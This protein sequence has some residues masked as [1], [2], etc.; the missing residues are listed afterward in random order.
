MR[1]RVTIVETETPCPHSTA[2]NANRWGDGV[3]LSDIEPLFICKASGKR[4]AE[5][6]SDFPQAR[7]GTDA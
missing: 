2:I 1:P 3:Q 6:R 5:V 4:D 7:M